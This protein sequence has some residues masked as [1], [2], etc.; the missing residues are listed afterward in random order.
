MKSRVATWLAA[1][2]CVIAATLPVAPAVQAAP[3]GTL[4]WNGAT[5]SPSALSAQPSDTFDFANNSA[6]IIQLIGDLDGSGSACNGATNCQVL[7]GLSRTFTVVGV[8]LVQ[9]KNL[10]TSTIVTTFYTDGSG[11]SSS[12]AS[13]SDTPAPIVQQFGKP[14]TGTCDAA[15]PDMLSIG[16][17]ESG[18]WSESWAEWMNGGLGGAVCT[19]TLVYSSALGHW[20]VG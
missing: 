2:G 15:Q 19:R 3:L 11:A 14:I 4:T 17:A 12:S 10:T 13:S 1:T 16:G 20:V 5:L 7:S 6:D 8:G 9:V 18:G